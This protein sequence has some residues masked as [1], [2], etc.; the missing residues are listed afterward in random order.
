MYVHTQVLSII[1]APLQNI[2]RMSV[3]VLKDTKYS[4]YAAVCTQKAVPV[5]L[6]VGRSSTDSSH[7]RLLK[8][9]FELMARTVQSCVFAGTNATEMIAGV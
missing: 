9:V 7:G 4:T 5:C 1:L 2:A 8:G 3:R 6:P